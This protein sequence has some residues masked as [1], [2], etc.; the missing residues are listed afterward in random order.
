MNANSHIL[1]PHLAQGGACV[2]VSDGTIMLRTADEAIALIELD[3]IP[4]TRQGRIR[5]QVLNALAAAAAAWAAGV[6]PA[7]IARALTT[8]TTDAAM[9]PGRFNVTDVNGIEI[10]LDYAHNAAAMHALS[11]AVVEMGDRRTHVILTLPG[12]RADRD[13]IR[14]FQAALPMAHAVWLHDSHDRRGRAVNAV[15]ELLLSHAPAEVVCAVA[16]DQHDALMQA[17]QAVR[18][19]DRLVVIADVVDETLALLDRLSRSASDSAGCVHP[20]EQGTGEASFA[21][22][23][24]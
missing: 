18:P 1:K 16:R 6:N 15:P 2:C 22:A 20:V 10:I 13:L 24:R 5:F 4:F 12:D 21:W 19:G 11:E 14:T 3:R 9:T 8:F 7:L 23:G 17:W